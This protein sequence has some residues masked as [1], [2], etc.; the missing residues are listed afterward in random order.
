MAY[1]PYLGPQRQV[2]G[3]GVSPTYF[4]DGVVTFSVDNLAYRWGK[5]FWVAVFYWDIV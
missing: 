5:G 2:F 4:E 3:G 1:I